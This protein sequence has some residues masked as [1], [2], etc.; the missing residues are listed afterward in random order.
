[1][2]FSLANLDTVSYYNVLIFEINHV[3]NFRGMY[4]QYAEMQILILGLFR[5]L[6]EFA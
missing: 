4:S 2:N 5:N 1:M 3:K 6:C